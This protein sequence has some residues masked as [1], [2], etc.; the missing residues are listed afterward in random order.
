MECV[1]AFPL[2]TTASWVRLCVLL[3]WVNAPKVVSVS[4]S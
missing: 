2:R 1:C 4:P 3:H